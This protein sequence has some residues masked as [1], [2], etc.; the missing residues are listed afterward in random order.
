MKNVLWYKEPAATW[1]DALPLGNGHIGAMVFGRVEEER[2]ALNDDTLWSGY[3][4]KK[5]NPDALEYLPKVQKLVMEGNIQEAQA[6][7]NKHLAGLFTECYLPLGDL[8]I[9]TEIHGDVT[10]F[11]RDLDIQQGIAAVSFSAG[12]VRYGREAFVSAPSD[13]FVMLLS[14]TQPTNYELTMESQL[15]YNLRVEEQTLYM[16]GY[17]PEVAMPSYYEC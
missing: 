14:A 6:L 13:A 12:D 10:N 5:E 9:R 8:K 15:R 3:P 4:K 2:I 16:R 7:A 17:A 11:I 1:E